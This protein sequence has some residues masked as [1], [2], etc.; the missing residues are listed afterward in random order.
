MPLIGK[1]TKKNYA[2][3]KKY[4]QGVPLS[5]VP[6]GLSHPFVSQSLVSGC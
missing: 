5:C 3:Y 6:R 4:R 1:Y 2:V